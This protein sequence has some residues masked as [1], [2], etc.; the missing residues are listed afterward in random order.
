MKNLIAA[1]MLSM[2]MTAGAQSFESLKA[3]SDSIDFTLE[4]F[5]EGRQALYER[6]QQPSGPAYA[7]GEIIVQVEMSENKSLPDAEVMAQKK[8]ALAA[9]L[10]ALPGSIQIDTQKSRDSVFRFI[11]MLVLKFNEDELPMSEALRLVGELPGVKSATPNSIMRIQKVGFVPERQTPSDEAIKEAIRK[12]PCNPDPKVQII[13][14]YLRSQYQQMPWLTPD[15]L[16]CL[17]A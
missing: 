1:L 8:A 12:G 6:H 13:Y 14:M 7:P 2:S 11:G 3:G 9:Q 15:S 5:N 4:G 16:K 10:S 17:K